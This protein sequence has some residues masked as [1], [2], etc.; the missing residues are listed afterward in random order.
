MGKLIA[1]RTPTPRDARSFVVAVNASTRLHRPWV[2][3]PN[4]PAKFEAYLDRMSLP[5]NTGF[6]VCHNDSDELAGVIN[7]TNIVRG[8]FR[9]G[10]LDY[11]VFAD[12][13][14]QGFMR[15]GLSAVT[16]HAF[17]KLGLHRLEANIQP[18]NIASIALAKSCGFSREGYSPRY[19]KLGG[20]WRD[21]ERWAIL[22]S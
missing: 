5:E 2:A 10:Y 19:L 12:H 16:R 18:G 14:R 4:T 9:S 3:P 13:E 1:I 8:V 15:A 21:H 17:D 20:R 6:L 11:Y 22:A 7:I